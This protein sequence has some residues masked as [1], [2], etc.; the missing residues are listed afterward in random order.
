MDVLVM[1]EPAG[2]HHDHRQPRSRL[3][4]HRED[5]HRPRGRAIDGH[6]SRMGI[7]IRV[8]TNEH[9]ASHRTESKRIHLRARFAREGDSP[10]GKE[11]ALVPAGDERHGD[12]HKVIAV[13]LRRPCAVG[14][15][16]KPILS[17][18]PRRAVDD[19]FS[20]QPFLQIHEGVHI[21]AA[22]Q[23]RQVVASVNNLHVEGHPLPVVG[24]V[25]IRGPD[26]IIDI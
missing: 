2:P 8:Q 12:E 13:H 3:G 25:R 21:P 1:H 11:W 7:C 20:E 5:L 15:E 23:L 19:G 16:A 26:G 9:L 14:G 24:G 17:R 22:R 6:G 18:R 4:R 10:K